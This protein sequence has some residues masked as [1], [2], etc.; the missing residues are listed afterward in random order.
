MASRAAV[1]EATGQAPAYH[2]PPPGESRLMILDMSVL[3][4]DSTVKP[5]L[6]KRFFGE[7]CREGIE[8][9]TYV[10]SGSARLLF[11]TRLGTAG[12]FLFALSARLIGIAWE[13]LA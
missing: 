13:V 10:C 4:R 6:K 9:W 3:A 5:F 8:I 2:Y 1:A 12:P 11:S 7:N